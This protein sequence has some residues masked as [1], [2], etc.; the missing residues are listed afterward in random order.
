MT[1]TGCT[2]GDLRLFDDG[3]TNSNTELVQVCYDGSWSTLCGFNGWNTHSANIVCRQL[4]YLEYG[5]YYY[6]CNTFSQR[7]NDISISI[8][9]NWGRSFYGQT[10]FTGTDNFVYLASSCRGDETKLTN[11]TL[12]TAFPTNCNYGTDGYVYAAVTCQPG[13]LIRYNIHSL[14]L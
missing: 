5:K 9:A 3:D 8:G 10:M 14:Q 1:T 6:S 4:G 11:C 12:R 2:T 7:N 13:K